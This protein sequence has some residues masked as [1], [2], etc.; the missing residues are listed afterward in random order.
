MS[1]PRTTGKSSR[2]AAVVMLVVF[3]QV[4]IVA[5]LGLGAIGRGRGEAKREAEEQAAEQAELAMARIVKGARKE[6]FAALR[7]VRK[8]L[9]YEELEWLRAHGG[10]GKHLDLVG[11]VYQVDPETREIFWMDGATRLFVPKEQRMKEIRRS[12]DKDYDA[13]AEQLLAD[14]KDGR[15]KQRLES[16][17]GFCHA[18]PYRQ[19]PDTGYPQALGAFSSSLVEEAQVYA[20][21][22]D[23]N[24]DEAWET[25]Q[26]VLLAAIEVMAL[27]K[28]RED[29]LPPGDRSKF[30]DLAAQIESAIGAPPPDRVHIRRHIDACRDARRKLEGPNSLLTVLEVALRNVGTTESVAYIGGRLV[31][32]VPHVR[33]PEL[34][35]SR[36]LLV[37]L[38]L[39]AA[40]YLVESAG[41]REYEELLEPLGLEFRVLPKG[42][43]SEGRL[44]VEHDLSNQPGLRIPYRAELVW[45]KPPKAPVG[46]PGELFYWGI[47]ALSAAGLGMGGWVLM[48]LYT[49][50][51]RLARVKADFVSNLSHELKTPLT[52]IA[53]WTEMLQD[54]ALESD[55][56]RNEG[57]GIL[58]QEAERLQQIVHRMLDTAKR[59]ARGVDYELTPGDLNE[60][61]GAAAERFRR[62]TAEPGL[63]LTIALHPEPLPVR[64][65]RAAIDDTISNLVSNAWKYKKGSEV[66]IEV[67]TTRRGR[68]AEVTVADDGLGIPRRER[69]RVFEMFYRADAYLTRA[70]GTGLGLS[71]VRTI[72]KAHKGWVRIENGLDG[73]GS[74][75]RI[76]LP[77]TKAKLP[78]AETDSPSKSP[79]AQT[80]S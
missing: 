34:G 47:I 29:E 22:A 69:S 78:P 21:T 24:D 27:N 7:D 18:F 20:N 12:K 46:G 5:V 41:E 52:S 58:T 54:G 28:D 9:T 80:T 75:F 55:E 62:I 3:V 25:L 66:R 48:R 74:T 44:A 51:V 67:R 53:M 42:E 56:D 45:V 43:V 30:E 33:I 49:R 65:D 59:E 10:H 2:T 17:L 68:K 72:V 77:L 71:L 61:V 13:R 50:E 6:V 37:I 19:H 35:A 70:A 73:R 39:E 23:P 57:L 63:D 40:R 1:D 76:R 4:L 15:G 38:S 79:E 11:T 8:N 14:Y 31:G 16:G 32:I 64:M 60:V 36:H 26:N